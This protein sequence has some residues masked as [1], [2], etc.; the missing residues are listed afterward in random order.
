M[1]N[2]EVHL[3]DCY[4]DGESASLTTVSGTTCPCCADGEYSAEWHRNNADADDCNGTCLIDTTTTTTSVKGFFAHVG[5][6]TRTMLL[7]K[8]IKTLIGELQ[9]DDVIC[10]GMVNAT[11]AAEIDMDGLSELADTLTYNSD[12]YVFRQSI[13]TNEF[14]QIGIFKRTA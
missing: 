10:Y 13:K 12:T 4:H 5:L 6:I 11:T 3:V 9:Q 7:E 1:T 8:E 2:K 14:G